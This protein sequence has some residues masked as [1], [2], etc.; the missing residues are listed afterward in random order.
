[1]LLSLPRPRPRPPRLT[2]LLTNVRD[3]SLEWKKG[4]FR[5]NDWALEHAHTHTQKLISRETRKPRSATRVSTAARSVRR[6]RVRLE[7]R[8]LPSLTKPSRQP[9]ASAPGRGPRHAGERRRRGEGG[10]RATRGLAEVVPGCSYPSLPRG[11]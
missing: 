5:F 1:M 10:G 6:R 11:G 9:V 8:R 3:L 4:S 2:F 7:E